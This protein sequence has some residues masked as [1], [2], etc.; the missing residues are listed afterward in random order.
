MRTFTQ[1]IISKLI[2]YRFYNA[3]K[4]L[5][6][7]LRKINGVVHDTN[8]KVVNKL[9]GKTNNNLDFYIEELIGNK[10]LEHSFERFK[11]LY[12]DN[13]YKNYKDKIYKNLGYIALTYCVIR[14]K[15]PK[16]IVETGTAAGS[17]TSFLL[18]ALSINKRGKLISI[19]IQPKKK[20]SLTYDGKLGN[21]ERG[22]FIPKKYKNRWLFISGDS[23]IYLPK[24]MQKYNVDFFIHDSLHTYDHMSFEYYTA[25]INMKS[26]TFIASDDINN[27]NSAFHDFCAANKLEGWSPFLN[28]NFGI[29]K[30]I[31]K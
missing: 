23:K 21:K 12:K 31:Y 24:I 20:N 28:P 26:N 22:A 1:K 27:Y 19:D 10:D 14:E 2:F 16:V 18:A 15:K 11:Y 4:V 29:V 3:A 17:L 5:A 8:L 13:K 9:I 7:I 6:L 25:R 30:N